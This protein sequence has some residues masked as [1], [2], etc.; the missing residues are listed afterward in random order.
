MGGG[1][2]SIRE[3]SE[4]GVRVVNKDM[5]ETMEEIGRVCGWM[6]GGILGQFRKEAALKTTEQTGKVGRVMR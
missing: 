5:T 3:D 1:Q 6:G 2:K 4:R